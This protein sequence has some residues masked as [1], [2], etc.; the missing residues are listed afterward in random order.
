[1]KDHNLIYEINHKDKQYYAYFLGVME[2][3]KHLIFLYN[4]DT[5]QKDNKCHTLSY[6]SI[7]KLLHE[8]K[9]MIERY[10]E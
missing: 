1:M 10:L 8:D 5:I 3:P 4:L 6:N 2:S 7:E 9:E